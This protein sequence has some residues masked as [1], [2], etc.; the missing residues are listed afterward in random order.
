MLKHTYDR[1]AKVYHYQDGIACSLYYEI[2]FQASV[3][4]NAPVFWKAAKSELLNTKQYFALGDVNFPVLL[5]QSNSV[6]C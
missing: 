6:W 1:R 4:E 5:I 2:S 3:W